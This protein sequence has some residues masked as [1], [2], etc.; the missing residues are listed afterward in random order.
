[1]TDD[2]KGRFVMAGFSAN[3]SPG[4]GGKK[5]GHQVRRGGRHHARAHGRYERTDLF[6][7]SRLSKIIRFQA[8]EVRPKKA[9]SKAST[10]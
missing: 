9:S 7:I 3:K 5:G 4:S 10:A 1:M 2:G 6:A 8:E